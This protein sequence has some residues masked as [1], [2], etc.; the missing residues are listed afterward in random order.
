MPESEF[1][2]ERIRRISEYGSDA[3]LREIADSGFGWVIY[4]MLDAGY[5]QFLATV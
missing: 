4:N 1:R 2:S 5:C 3:S